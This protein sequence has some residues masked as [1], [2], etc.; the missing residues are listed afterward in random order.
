MLFPWL[1][2]HPPICVL[3]LAKAS[4][5]GEDAYFI[6]SDKHAFGVADGVGG[7]AL[8][9]VD[10]GIYSRK[11]MSGAKCAAEAG[12]RDPVKLMWAG[13]TQARKVLGS[14]TAVILVLEGQVLHT[15]NLGE[16]WIYG[17]QK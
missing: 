1:Y 15:A 2:N 9:G 11:L 7:W 10:S 17:H 5:G 13:F 6:S 4:K 8:Q 3:F 16:L 14:S 12:E